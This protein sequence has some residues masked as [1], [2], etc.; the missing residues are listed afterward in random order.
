MY[1][2]FSKIS[3]CLYAANVDDKAYPADAFMIAYN[4]IEMINW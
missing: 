3:I 4:L 2:S 1:R